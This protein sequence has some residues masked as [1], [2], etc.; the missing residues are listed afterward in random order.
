MKTLV[1]G[2]TRFVGLRLVRYLSELGHDITILNRGRTQAQLPPGIKRLYADRRNSEEVVNALAGQEFEVIFDV[3]GYEVRNLEPVVELYAGKIAHYVFLSTAEVYAGS[4]CL[5]ILEEFPRQSSETQEKG[6]AAYGVNKVQCED[7]LLQKY[8]E[9]GFPATILRCP[10]IYGSENWMHDREF[11]FFVRLLQ[12]REIFVP[13]N[14]ANIIHQAYVDD[15][16]RAQVSVVGKEK[17][18]GQAFNIASAEAITIDGYIDTVAEIL[19]VEAKKVYLDFEVIQNLKRPVF[20]F[21]GTHNAFFGIHK[22][23]EYLDFWPAYSVKE[24]L[25]NTYKWWES[26]LGIAGTRFEPGRLGH[27]VDLAY[28]D[29]LAEQ[30]R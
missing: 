30:H 28:E 27:N 25:E 24:G 4:R 18:P 7:F 12:E 11:S 19:G 10:V 16:A 29:E 13:G 6:L 9:S 20:P 26:S 2:G 1:L 14:G 15:V 5:P 8:Q 21:G 17:A 23:Q 3:T 22:A